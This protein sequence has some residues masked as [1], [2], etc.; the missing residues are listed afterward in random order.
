MRLIAGLIFS[1]MIF[2]AQGVDTRP[3]FLFIIS[4]D[5]SWQH[6]SY[7]GYAAVKTPAFD[8]IAEEGVYFKNAFVS[9]PSCTESRSAI[10]S[11]RHFW[12]TGS[13]ALLWGQYPED[14]PNFVQ[15][16]SAS[17]YAT[18]SIGKS[19]GP[20]IVPKGVEP[21]GKRLRKHLKAT[22]E[23]DGYRGMKG[24]A[25]ELDEFLQQRGDEAPFFAWVGL[26]EPHRE[27]LDKKNSRFKQENPP[28]LWPA[29]MPDTGRS[30]KQLSRYLEEIEY[31]DGEVSQMLQHLEKRKLLENTVV[32]YTSDNGMPFP[33]AKGNLYRYGLQVP[34]AIRWS[35]KIRP[36]IRNRDEL[37]SLVDLAPTILE[38][39]AVKHDMTFSGQSLL[40]LMISDKSAG[41]TWQPRDF[42]LA[43]FERH[44]PDA[45]Q[46]LSTYPARA[47][48]TPDWF[49]IRNYQSDRWPMG[50]PMRKDGS[51]GYWDAAVATLK[52]YK[53]NNIEPFFSE[54][55]GK[56]PPRELYRWAD[57]P[58][59]SHNK[60]SDPQYRDIVQTL[61]AQLESA[62]VAAK[63]PGVT[64]RDYFFKR[65]G[66]HT[67]PFTASRPEEELP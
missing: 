8:R 56:R 51:E 19:W 63:D 37:V 43:G 16:L 27:Y 14:M 22:D 50:D 33:G 49:Y 26:F 38:L 60:A 2:P 25:A 45:R 61:D 7:G 12:Q 28:S 13:G 54:L 29:F 34:L 52:T 30:Q 58:G 39:A 18:I 9:A 67:S 21:T 32:I 42:V 24:Y 15:S 55:L 31:G 11:G 5:Q 64:D 10:L 40:P 46:D 47:I 23:Q 57:A 48:I 44:V 59:P 6:T 35:K 3:N 4:D 66:H 20:G 17:G 36:A 53:N 41:Q 62:L 65:Y 1:L